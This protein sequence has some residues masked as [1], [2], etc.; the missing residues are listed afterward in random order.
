MREIKER[1]F[2]EI[3]E[4]IPSQQLMVGTLQGFLVPKTNVEHPQWCEQH[5]GK[6]Q[7][8]VKK[9]VVEYQRAYFLLNSIS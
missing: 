3:Q 5:Q 4:S 2:C 6:Y 7:G 1:E 9:M 8:A